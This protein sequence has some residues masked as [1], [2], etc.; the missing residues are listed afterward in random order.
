MWSW[1]DG[2]DEVPVFVWHF[3]PSYSFESHAGTRLSHRYLYN[4]PVEQVFGMSPDE[5]WPL[6]DLDIEYREGSK[7]ESLEGR[8][9]RLDKSLYFAAVF[10]TL[11]K[12]ANYVFTAL[13]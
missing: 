4:A 6:L 3:F 7:W 9:G 13:G 1:D 10:V 2:W 5:L 8:G 12:Y 11:K